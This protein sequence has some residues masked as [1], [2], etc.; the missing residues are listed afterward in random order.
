MRHGR[1]RQRCRLPSAGR[2]LFRRVRPFAEGT[3]WETG[4]YRLILALENI[5]Y[6]ETGFDEFWVGEKDLPVI[7]TVRVGHVKTPMGLEGDMTAS[8]RCMTFMERS[9]YSAAIEMEQNF[10]TGIWASNNYL[11]ERVTWSAAAFRTDQRPPAGNTS[12]PARAAC[13]AASRPCRSTKTRAANCCTS[14]SPAVGGN[15]HVERRQRLP[16]QHGRIAGPGPNCATMTLPAAAAPPANADSNPYGRHRRARVRPRVPHGPG[17][18]VHP[19]AVLVP[20]RVRLELSRQRN[21]RRPNR[22]RS[23][24]RKFID[25]LRTTSSA[26]DT[27]RWPTP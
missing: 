14:A 12:A 21:G 4:E 6:G 25:V 15:G 23:P 27:S 1:H 3:F 18:L 24:S 26:A 13:R 22:A 11:D 17:G 2:R 16:G 20:G 5:Q 19:R 7:G 10:V 9:S 8:S